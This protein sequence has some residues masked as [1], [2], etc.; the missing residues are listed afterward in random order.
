MYQ[1][2]YH[3]KWKNIQYYMQLEWYDNDVNDKSITV[4]GDD[5]WIFTH[6]V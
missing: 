4:D 3:D 1:Y 2:E 5:Q 6:K